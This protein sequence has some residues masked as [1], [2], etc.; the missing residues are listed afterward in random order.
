[1]ELVGVRWNWSELR[2]NWL[3]VRELHPAM[4]PMFAV[5]FK[6]MFA[7][8]SISCLLY[9]DTNHVLTI[10]S[11]KTDL[12]LYGLIETINRLIEFFLYISCLRENGKFQSFIIHLW[13]NYNLI[14][15]SLYLNRTIHKQSNGETSLEKLELAH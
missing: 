2:R 5:S 10:P 4:G 3:D 12:H 13:L 9:N 8:S 7:V 11:S 15:I 6:P 14:Y 1:M